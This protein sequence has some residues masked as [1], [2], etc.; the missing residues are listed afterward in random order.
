MIT[1]NSMQ[2]DA[3]SAIDIYAQME[4]DIYALIFKTIKTTKYD[5]VDADNA[6][7]W[8]L[9]Q[10]SKMGV[11][12]KQVIQL[13]SKY[14][15]KSEEAIE[16]LVQDNGIQIVDEVDQEL[17]DLLHKK[18]DV[19]DDTRDIIN[20][21]LNQTMHDLDNTVSQTLLTTSSAHNSAVQVFQNIVKQTTIATSTGLKTHQQALNETCEKWISNGIPVLVDK[22]GRR[23]SIEGYARTVIQSTSHRTFNNLRLKR[24]ED[25]GTHLALMSSHPAAREACAPIQGKVINLVPTSSK[26][27]NPKYDSIYNHGY[28]EASGVLGI[29]CTHV[30]YPFIEELNTNNQPQ[31]D[32]DEAIK[33]G[34]LQAKQRGYERA[35]RDTKKKLEAA[36]ALGDEAGIQHYKSLLASQQKRLREFIKPHDFLHRDYSREKIFNKQSAN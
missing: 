13:V 12:N 36:K 25:Y 9:E 22:A 8:Q 20:S 21:Q 24:M 33:N 28:G 19:G 35:I 6:L 17:S 16:H 27:Y 11:L 7:A 23:R 2:Q 10:L 1:P 15:H 34:E 14:T 5:S 31:Y 29:N 18:V 32:E 4:Q 30:L 3:N 26:D